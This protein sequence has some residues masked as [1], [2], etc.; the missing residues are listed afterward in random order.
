MKITNEEAI[1]ELKAMLNALDPRFLTW[2]RERMK[3][4]A[5]SMAID[6]MEREDKDDK[7]NSISAEQTDDVCNG[8]TIS[9]DWAVAVQRRFCTRL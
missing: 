3:V 6:L 9:S 8:R 2:D 7:R 4:E 1:K 5:L